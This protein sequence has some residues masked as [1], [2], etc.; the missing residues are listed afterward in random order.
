LGNRFLARRARQQLPENW[1]IDFINR[2]GFDFADWSFAYEP[3]KAGTGHGT[4]R[5]HAADG[6]FALQSRDLLTV[7][8]ECRL[9]VA[10]T[11]ARG[12]KIMAF[13]YV[14]RKNRTFLTV[15]PV[16]VYRCVNSG[17]ILLS[18]PLRGS[19][20]PAEGAFFSV[21]LIGWQGDVALKKIDM[22]YDD[23]K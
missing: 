9:K 17:D 23:D 2:R 22:V 10:A 8:G 13:L 11:A 14:Y 7:K 19:S 4:V 15:Q 12:S 20:L 6:G 3:P 16:G 1:N 5:F 21:G 18:F